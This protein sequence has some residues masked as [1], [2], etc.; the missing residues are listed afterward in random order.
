MSGGQGREG[1]RPPLLPFNPQ[2]LGPLQATS[3]LGTWTEVVSCL[4]VALHH[5][6]LHLGLPCSSCHTETPAA[7][8]PSGALHRQNV[9]QVSLFPALGWLRRE[10]S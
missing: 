8:Q 4:P 1:A 5:G 9:L 2:L 6:L 10:A 7:R 3:P